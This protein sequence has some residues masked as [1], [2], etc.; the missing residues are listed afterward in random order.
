MCAVE[1]YVATQEGREGEKANG[2]LK[3]YRLNYYRCR[4]A[5]VRLRGAG[6]GGGWGALTNK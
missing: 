3:N 5:E 1:K 2:K 4:R 6:G